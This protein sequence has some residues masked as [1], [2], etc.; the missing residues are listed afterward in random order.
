MDL[1]N[2][3]INHTPTLIE[4]FML[5]GK[6]FKHLGN[7]EEAVNCFDEAQS[8]DTADRYINCKCA[9]YLLR[10]NKI[11]DAE[12]MCQKFTREGVS[13]TESLNEMQ[14]MWFQTEC[15]LAF[16]RKGQYGEAL[17]KCH[18]V[19]RVTNFFSI[20]KKILKSG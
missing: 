11:R 1:V 2:E 16:Q 7:L 15:A 18:E 4:L 3:S 19:E 6:I 20:P 17:K 14:C 13:A 8:L 5:K 12:E 9:K 10:A